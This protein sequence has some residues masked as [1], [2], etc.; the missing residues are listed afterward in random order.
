MPLRLNPQLPQGNSTFVPG[1]EVISFSQSPSTHSPR[2][3]SLSL[4]YSPLLEYRE[5]SGL[6]LF[7][8]LDVTGRTEI[9][10]VAEAMARNILQY[11]SDWK[12]APVRK[13]IY[14]GDP[15]GRRHLESAGIVLNVFERGNLR[16]D[17]VLVLGPSGGG[18]LEASKDAI[19]GWLKA[20]GNLMA[21][22]I[23]QRDADAVLPFKVNFTNAEH[24]AAFFEPNRIGSL[25]QGIGPADV[26]NRDPRKLPLVASGA[27]AI[28][29]GVLAR[30]QD[31]NVVFC[32]LAPWQ[33]DPGK[34]PNLKR[35]YRRASFAIAR[36]LA[37]LGVSSASPVVERFKSP[38]AS[39]QSEKRWLD[40]LYL[41]EP[42]EWDDPYRFFRW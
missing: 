27:V 22:G 7:C 3:G 26:H 18:E 38:V 29:N 1:K 15:A 6:I 5:A 4:Q 40:G 42:E 17:Q 8:Q 39:A 36:L 19:A 37:N 31:A 34:Q 10:P 12:P 9:D 11:V 41:D 32:Q 30:M 24:I 35:T 2:S 21:I 13:A 14:A 25:L 16:T 33:F 23:D 28:G 20:G